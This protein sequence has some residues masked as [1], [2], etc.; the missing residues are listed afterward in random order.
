MKRDNSSTLRLRFIHKLP[1]CD[2]S[3]RRYVI[4][5]LWLFLAL[6]P[7]HE[8]YQNKFDYTQWDLLLI[9]GVATF[10][11]GLNLVASLRGHFDSTLDRLLVRRIFR[12]D[13]EAKTQFIDRLEKHAQDWSRRGG[14]IAAFAILSAFA[15]VLYNEFYW[16]RAL[17]GIGETIG[18]YIVGTY[19]GRMASYGQLGWQLKKES[20]EI[21]LQPSHVDGVAGLKP[22]GDFYFYQAM[23]VA[24]PAIFLA[25]WWFIFPIWPR[26]Y[27]YWEDA[28]LV[29]LSIAILVEILAFLIP[30]WSFHRIMIQERVKQLEEAD[31]LS[32]EISELHLRKETSQD[33][34]TKD[35]LS[36]QI[37]DKT[38]HYW[39]IENMPIWPVDIKIKRRFK[40]N[41][42]LLFVPLLG[43]LAKRSIEWK[44][45]VELLKKFG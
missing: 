27:L 13:K 22:L 40:L 21:F 25:V 44:D 11:L 34:D 39:A 23:I 37:E 12:I 15:F 33:A 10:I 19:L 16:P 8:Y 4:Y 18:G 35:T 26:N 28:Y 30:V 38:Q 45:V 41:N 31:R 6:L 29:L 43:D 9:T 7:F 32:I 1:L 14:I 3:C 20:V 2:K 42:L 17:L 5:A 36:D 24:I